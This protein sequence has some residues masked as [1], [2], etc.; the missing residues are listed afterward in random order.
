MT[1]NLE[2]Q[3][4]KQ[5]ISTGQKIIHCIP[6]KVKSGIGKSDRTIV[7]TDQ[8]FCVFKKSSRKNSEFWITLSSLNVDENSVTFKFGKKQ[9]I[10]IPN[11]LKNFLSCLFDVIQRVL[12][13]SELDALSF[14]NFHSF[15]TY[16]NPRSVIARL[17]QQTTIK[18][19]EIEPSTYSQ[20][21]SSF[22]FSRKDLDIS[23]FKPSFIPFIIDAL[24]LA[25]EI[26]SVRINN[27]AEIDAYSEITKLMKEKN[28]IRLLE[29]SGTVNGSFEGFMSTLTVNKPEKL[30]SIS[31]DNSELAQK[32]LEAIETFAS[33]DKLKGLEFHNAISPSGMNYFHDSLF[34]NLRL[35]SLNLDRTPGIDL[36]RLI[37]R[38]KSVSLL[39]LSDCKLDISDVLPQ[40]SPL[41]QLRVLN[42]SGNRCTDATKLSRTQLPP[43]IL[44]VYVNRVKWER[45]CLAIFFNYRVM[46]L[47]IAYA[48][49]SADDWNRLF[50]SMIHNKNNSLAALIWDGNRVHI[51]LFKHIRNHELLD[52]LS[53]NYCF[54]QNHPEYLS[55][56]V[57]YLQSS[58]SHIRTLSVRGTDKNNLGIYIAHVVE[59]V[60]NSPRLSILDIYGQRGGDQ[61]LMALAKQVNKLRIISCDGMNPTNYVHL[62]TLLGQANAAGIAISYP[63]EDIASLV[64]SGQLSKE[65]AA[66]I[67]EKCGRLPDKVKKQPDD[68]KYQPV[69][70][71][72]DDL[73]Q[74]YQFKPNDQFPRY[75]KKKELQFWTSAPPMTN[76]APVIKRPNGEQIVH[77]PNSTPSSPFSPNRDNHDSDGPA[78]NNTNYER[79]KRQQNQLHV[80]VP[81]H[82]G[83][84][85][86]PKKKVTPKFVF[87][88]ESLTIEVSIADEE[89]ILPPLPPA[90]NVG[91]SPLV[92][93]NRSSPTS[94][95]RSPLKRPSSPERS[96]IHSPHSPNRSSN[97]PSSP[98]NKRSHSQQKRKVSSEKERERGRAPA[99]Q[100]RSASANRTRNRH[101]DNDVNIDR[102]S[103]TRRRQRKEELPKL[104]EPENKP[105]LRR[106]N[107]RKPSPIKGRPSPTEAGTSSRKRTSPKEQV[108]PIRQ[109]KSRN[110][111]Q[112]NDPHQRRQHHQ[113]LQVKTSS[114]NKNI[115]EDLPSPKIPTILNHSSDSFGD[116]KPLNIDNVKPKI[117]ES[118]RRNKQPSQ[119][120]H[121]LRDDSGDELPVQPKRSTGN[122]DKKSP[123]GGESRGRSRRP[124]PEIKEMNFGE[125]QRKG[126]IIF[127][128]KKSR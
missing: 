67:F 42:L 66:I 28:R 50:D 49:T 104:E 82:Y 10:I 109:R 17:K 75:L 68:I 35:T 29:I 46:K 8:S 52:Y 72:F 105:V 54:T 107:R 40:L 116:V 83:T 33:E 62:T 123:Q 25:Y 57:D 9:Y 120:V 124:A 37:P 55:Y 95:P 59:A 126:K 7:F 20:L 22:T 44:S 48:E 93:S 77:T 36:N 34:S 115:Q 12:L 103:S 98:S 73:F 114:R 127:A 60:Q 78:M 112:H 70:S 51:N 31:F 63:T 80:K 41:T 1:S 118:A 84:T 113:S 74:V 87:E 16:P 79:K 97:R 2:E 39:S 125:N 18:K 24:P 110:A 119:Q 43:S 81:Q 100:H 21:M 45:D 86:S 56:L 99:V 96:P 65:N 90:R 106:Q 4:S 47:S 30:F 122:R 32:H 85:K 61:C 111:E 89:S 27:T 64:S 76:I 14:G 94:S 3:V 5:V 91:R 19:Y 38:I 11:D 15:V 23:E 101:N 108:E 69:T 117:R 13:P 53:V 26:E 92:G 58:T 88:E 128:K 6:A 71:H 102:P 121:R